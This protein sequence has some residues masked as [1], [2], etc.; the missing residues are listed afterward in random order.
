MSAEA[1][2]DP[3]EYRRR[4]SDQGGRANGH[5]QG[6]R[7]KSDRPVV[8]A[9]SKFMM[10]AIAGSFLFSL[11]LIAWAFTLPF[12]GG[13]R[14]GAG[15]DVPAGQLVGLEY[16]ARLDP[17]QYIEFAR[18]KDDDLLDQFRRRRE[19]RRRFATERELRATWKQKTEGAKRELNRLRKE[20]GKDG[21]VEGS[22]EYE[23]QKQLE[24]VIQD[25]LQ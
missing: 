6:G 4:A 24:S 8:V 19:D 20:A 2:E 18:E 7:R 16:E 25:G 5:V 14:Q 13:T 11:S 15:A 10:I 1:P 21:F 3:S 12:R 22:I 23:Q 9:R 17:E